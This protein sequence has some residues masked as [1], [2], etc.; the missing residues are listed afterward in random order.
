MTLESF[1]QEVFVAAPGNRW[2]G[3]HELHYAKVHVGVPHLRGS[4]R[5]YSVP[6]LMKILPNKIGHA[7]HGIRAPGVG[8]QRFEPHFLPPLAQPNAPGEVWVQIDRIRFLPVTPDP[9]PEPTDIG[10]AWMPEHVKAEIRKQTAVT[11]FSSEIG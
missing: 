1:P 3:Q 11:P 6:I 2:N 9:I 4:L 8:R 7:S 5:S 10:Y